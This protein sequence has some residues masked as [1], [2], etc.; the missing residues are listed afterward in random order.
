MA[1]EKVDLATIIVDVLQARFPTD[2]IY[3]FSWKSGDVIYVNDVAYVSI[4]DDRS[5]VRVSVMG[6]MEK[7]LVDHDAKLYPGDPEF[8]DKLKKAVLENL[9]YYETDRST[10]I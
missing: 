4:Y 6:Y 1:D 10:R 3:T 9:I 8:F 2:K 5:Y 7:H